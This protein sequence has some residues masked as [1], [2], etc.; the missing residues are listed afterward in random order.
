MLSPNS[1]RLMLQ[2]AATRLKPILSP[3]QKSW[4]LSRARPHQQI[5]SSLLPSVL[6][7]PLQLLQRPQIQRLSYRTSI[8]CIVILTLYYLPISSLSSPTPTHPPIHSTIQ[9]PYDSQTA[10][11][12]HIPPNIWQLFGFSLAPNQEW[13]AEKLEP[14]KVNI[15]TWIALAPSSAYTLLSPQ[16]A[17]SIVS[18]LSSVTPHYAHYIRTYNALTRGVMKADFLRYLLLAIKGGVYSDIDTSLLKPI[19]QWVPEKWRNKTR[20]IVGV[21]GDKDP[22]VK[23][24]MYQVQFCQWTIAS[25]PNHPAM[26]AMVDRIAEAIEN[27]TTAIKAGGAD[28]WV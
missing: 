6:N 5:S 8:A 10:H 4:P 1:V 11:L 18:H 22:P 20:L 27:R 17:N 15:Y 21:E 14:Y 19:G 12:P 23:G 9:P 26:W 7:L 16:G 13:D 25:A 28:A 24:M 3:L 2:A